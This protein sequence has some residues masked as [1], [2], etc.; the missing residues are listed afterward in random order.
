MVKKASIIKLR[1][2]SLIR[3]I[4]QHEFNSKLFNKE[5]NNNEIYNELEYH[6][7][8]NSNDDNHFQSDGISDN[9][10]NCSNSASLFVTLVLLGSLLL[11]VFG[12]TYQFQQL[13]FLSFFFNSV[14][15]FGK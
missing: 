2:E 10:K 11:Y 6:Q 15:I 12:K 13:T 1:Q 5:V 14:I 3:K 9:N 7:A 8:L 4:K